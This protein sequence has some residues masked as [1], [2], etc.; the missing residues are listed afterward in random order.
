MRT[1]GTVKQL[2]AR[3][4]RGLA[5]LRRGK[6][7][8]S[9]A[10]LLGVT[11]RVVQLWQAEAKR[12]R[13]KRTTKPPGRPCRLSVAQLKRLEN[14]LRRGAPAHDYEADY[15]TLG[16]IVHLIWTLFG[17]RYL[18]SG[19]WYLLRRMRWSCQKPQRRAAQRDAAAI[20][21]WQRY[22]WPWIKKVASTRRK[23]CFRGRKWLQ[24]GIAAQAHLGTAG[25]NPSRPHESATSRSS[26]RDRRVG[27]FASWTQDQ[28]SH[29]NVSLQSHG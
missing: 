15:W 8:T 17:V 2:K 24:S 22:H 3:R 9:V 25:T 29:S 23:P 10:R 4:H 20:A 19:V 5:L 16:R 28:T 7:P 1:K 11:R 12:A 26:Q 6:G 14:H 27:H 13:P 21:H 18:P